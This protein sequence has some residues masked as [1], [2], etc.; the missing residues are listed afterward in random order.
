VQE[1]RPEGRAAQLRQTWECLKQRSDGVAER[2]AARVGQ[3]TIHE[4]ET[5]PSKSWLP[6]EYDVL[7]VEEVFATSGQQGLVELTQCSITQTIDTPV[8]QTFLQEAL[9]VFGPGQGT[10][11]R[12]A[13]R[14]YEHLYRNCGVWRFDEVDGTIAHDGAP[15]SILSS[16][17]YIE[18]LGHALQAVVEKL[19]GSG[20]VS[21][22]REGDKLRFAAS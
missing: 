5:A 10:V 14:V 17:A 21:V 9:R 16:E 3:A 19:T 6:V 7:M 8:L 18:V 20:S 12:A 11:M 4:L 2:F 1:H 22:T 13:T 15:E